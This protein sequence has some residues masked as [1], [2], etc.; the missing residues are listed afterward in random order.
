MITI[1][2]SHAP[3][4]TDCA[5][6]M[7]AGLES[8][9]Y[10]VWRAPEHVTPVDASYPYVV[11]NGILSSAAL[12]LV[13]SGSAARYDWGRRHLAFAQRLNKPVVVVLLDETEL[14]GTLLPDATVDKQ[15]A[16][17][18][19]VARVLPHLPALES[20]DALLTMETLAAHEFI[21]SRK[22]AIDL[23]A[24]MLQHG[25]YRAE[26]LA[27]LEYL[28]HND[29]ANGVREKARAV[30]D[31][32]SEAANRAIP[33]PAPAPGG[34]PARSQN[35]EAHHKF[36]VR[37]KNGHISTVDK[38]VVCAQRTKVAREMTR[39]MR[40]R[41]DELVLPCPICQVEMAIDIDCEGY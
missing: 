9:G 5:G 33:P 11:E 36:R 40:V 20:A 25:E 4:D 17:G 24:G 15:G 37:C 34:D 2:I 31:T 18:E 13:W 10:R 38:R 12:L 28:A 27:T 26:A 39:G 19:V 6:E 32:Q 21:R 3:E 14:P 22:E 29:L 30:L 1:F 16:C 7:C 8:K 23:A 35:D 41:L